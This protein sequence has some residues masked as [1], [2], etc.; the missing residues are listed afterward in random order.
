MKKFL[1]LLLAAVLCLGLLTACSSSKYIWANEEG[2][3]FSD[4]A[5]KY[6]EFDISSMYDENGRLVGMTGKEYVTLPEGYTTINIPAADITP[7]EEELDGYLDE[8]MQRFAVTEQITDRAVENGDTVNID[9]VGSVDGVA[10]QGGN[11]QGMGTDVTAGATNYIDDFLT[12]IIGHKPG[13]TFDVVVTF[14]D[15]YDASQDADGNPME[16]ANKEAVF[17]TTINYIHG[18]STVPECTD[19]WVKENV[20]FENVQE[21]RD[22][23]KSYYGERM[24]YDYVTQYVTDNA[25]YAELPQSLLD[26]NASMA[27]NMQYQMATQYG[28]EVE[29]WLSIQ[30]FDTPEAYLD[31]NAASVVENTRATLLLDALIEDMGITLSAEEVQAALGSYYQQYIATYGQNYTTMQAYAATCFSQLTDNAVVQE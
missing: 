25:V 8:F 13:E 3:S 7:T 22:D 19:D 21:M 2:V 4:D 10:F 17:E 24:K 12:Q 30:G 1:S 26:Y 5:L 31:A 28:A 20:G 11:T 14:P 18:E 23:M 29:Q 27:M 6:E 16:L 9:Y 15:G